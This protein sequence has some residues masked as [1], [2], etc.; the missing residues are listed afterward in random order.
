MAANNWSGKNLRRHVRKP[1]WM[2]AGIDMGDG[3]PLQPCNIV[4][5]SHGGARIVFV[6]SEPLPNRFWLCF[7]DR[8]RRQC[9]VAWRNELEIGI[10]YVEMVDGMLLPQEA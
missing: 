9:V 10:R 2:R 7:S 6:N 8:V 3:S 4:E 5:V 1:M